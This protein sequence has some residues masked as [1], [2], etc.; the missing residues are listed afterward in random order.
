MSNWRAKADDAL[1]DRDNRANSSNRSGAGAE[2]G[3]NA[4]IVPNVPTPQ[5][6]LKEW[7]KALAALH[8]CEPQG[9]PMGRWQTLYDCAVWLLE[10]FGEQTARDGWSTADLFG[11]RAG[12]P[13]TGGLAERLGDNRGLVLL[14][15]RARWRSWGVA[16]Q[17]N[18]GGGDGLLAFWECGE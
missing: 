9:M 15:G 3:A 7:R 11:L 2:R 6:R 17:F 12:Y 13:G 10:N 4:P 1:R 8:P 14:D 18:R 16:M 5:A